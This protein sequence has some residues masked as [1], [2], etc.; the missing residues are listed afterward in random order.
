MPSPQHP[1]TYTVG[2]RGTKADFKVSQEQ[3]QRDGAEVHRIKRGGETTFHGPGQVVQSLQL[4][5]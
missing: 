1:P 3:L 5:L 2:K 4:H